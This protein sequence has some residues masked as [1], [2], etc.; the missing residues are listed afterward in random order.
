VKLV[1]TAQLNCWY[2]QPWRSKSIWLAW[3]DFLLV[4]YRA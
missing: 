3:C 2:G 4:S 1:T